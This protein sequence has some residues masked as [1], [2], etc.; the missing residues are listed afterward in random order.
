MSLRTWQEDFFKQIMP[1]T[2]QAS[3][4][5]G[6]VAY[7]QSILTAQLASLSTTFP[8]LK[9]LIGDECF[10]IIASEYLSSMDPPIKLENGNLNAIAYDIGELGRDFSTFIAQHDITQTLP[11]IAELALYEWQWHQTFNAP[12]FQFAPPLLENALQQEQSDAILSPHPHIHF[13]CYH[14]RVH[15]LWQ[16]CQP[17]YTGDFTVDTQATRLGLVLY[18]RDL[19]VE[20]MQV[21]PDLLTLLSYFDGVKTLD[22]V[23]NLYQNTDSRLTFEA[24]LPTLCQFGLVHI[25]DDHS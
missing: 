15:E 13:H 4:D 18:R 1:Q 9:R 3:T 21:D 2:Q 6:V 22:T 12:H 24:V 11:Y 23:Y 10:E 16:C 8:A 7:Q 20:V 5:E 25:G 14:Y 19:Q 17:D